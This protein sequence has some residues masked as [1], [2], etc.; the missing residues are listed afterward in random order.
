MLSG[1]IKIDSST[2][3]CLG[4]TLLYTTIVESLRTKTDVL[5]AFTHWYLTSLG[6]KC[7]QENESYTE[8]LSVN[9]N[10]T[11]SNYLCYKKHNHKYVLHWITTENILVIKFLVCGLLFHQY[12]FNSTVF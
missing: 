11:D 8:L 6:L 12:P 4:W 1:E 2:V 9:W 5:I 3:K 10:E 7:H